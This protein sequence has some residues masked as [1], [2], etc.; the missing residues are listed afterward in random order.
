MNPLEGLSEKMIDL[1]NLL[2]VRRQRIEEMFSL[3]EG[4]LS[5]VSE[6]AGK[7]EVADR[8]CTKHD[9]PW[10]CPFDDVRE[11]LALMRSANRAHPEV[12]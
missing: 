5:R 12:W 4:A 10:P 6:I 1:E 9:V 8:R 2:R 11:I 3:V 7:C